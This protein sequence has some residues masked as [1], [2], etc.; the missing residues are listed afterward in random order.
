MDDA[1]ELLQP[2]GVFMDDAL[3][4]PLGVVRD[5]EPELLGSLQVVR[6]YRLGTIN[7]SY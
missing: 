2:V 6:D 1:A 4:A 7:L 3:L 5:Y